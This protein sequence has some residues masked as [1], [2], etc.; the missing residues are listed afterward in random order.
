MASTVAR[1]AMK[2]KIVKARR[3]GKTRAQRL[4]GEIV[5]LTKPSMGRKERGIAEPTET[6]QTTSSSWEISPRPHHASVDWETRKR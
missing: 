6:Y 4:K 3:T 2:Y 5:E 1:T